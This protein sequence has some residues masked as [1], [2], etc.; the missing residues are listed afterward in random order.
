MS[1]AISEIR[2]EYL[3]LLASEGRER[4]TLMM[5]M[6]MHDV[7]HIRRREP[8]LAKSSKCMDSG[9]LHNSSG[10]TSQIRAEH[11]IRKQMQNIPF[12]I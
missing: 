4:F 2:I 8:I 7:G 12:K 3:G 11:E 9:T 10:N 1:L 5:M 6:M